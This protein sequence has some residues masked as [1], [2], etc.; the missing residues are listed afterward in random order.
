LEL[1]SPPTFFAIKHCQLTKT[2]NVINLEQ[3]LSKKLV[4]VCANSDYLAKYCMIGRVN[5]PCSIVKKDINVMGGDSA[6]SI[7]ACVASVQELG[8]HIPI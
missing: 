3:S 5:C 2:Q 1:K 7:S 6:V 8:A 4:H